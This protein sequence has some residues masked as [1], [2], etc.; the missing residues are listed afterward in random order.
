MKY[1]LLHFVIITS[2]IHSQNS[3]SSIV[4]YNSAAEIP[5]T[6]KVSL[7]VG[8]NEMIF[9]DI[10]PFMVENTLKISCSD[11]STEIISVTEKINFISISNNKKIRTSKLQKEI[12]DLKKVKGLTNCRVIALSVEKDLLFHDE[13]IGGLSYG[14]SVAQI[15]KASNFFRKRYTDIVSTI[16][17]LKDSLNLM[18]KNLSKLE[19]QLKQSQVNVE[20]PTS[21]IHLIVNS[22]TTLTN[23]FLL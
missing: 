3:P 15:E 6:E 5:Y 1:L 18:E 11:K 20:K 23:L 14:V 8:K 17:L 4:L 10:T 9:R 19:N 21:E 22:N 12:T 7:N 13:S 16:Y 2:T